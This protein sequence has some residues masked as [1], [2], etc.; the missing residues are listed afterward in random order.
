MALLLCCRRRPQAG[1][2]LSHLRSCHEEP[3][4]RRHRVAQPNDLGCLA[5]HGTDRP[6]ALLPR[7]GV[8]GGARLALLGPGAGRAQPRP[9]GLGRLPVPLSPLGRQAA[10]FGTV[11]AAGG[12]PSRLW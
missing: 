2:H 3:A 6:F 1:L 4:G 10:A 12:D 11:Q 7:G 8:E 5:P 9:V